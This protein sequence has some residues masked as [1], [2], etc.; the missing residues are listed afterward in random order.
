MRH[1]IAIAVMLASVRPAAADHVTVTVVEVAGGVA[2]LDKGT[3][4]GVVRG[5][6]ITF[7]GTVFVVVEATQATAVVELGAS[8]L[9]VGAKGTAVVTKD[10]ATVTVLPKPRPLEA[11]REQW[12]RAEVPAAQQNPAHVALGSGRARSGAS[13]TVI[14]HGVAVVDKTRTDASAEGRVIASFDLM[15][16]RPLAADVDVAGRIYKSGANSL[17]RT[18][19]FVRAAQLRYGDATDPRFAI[20]RLRYAASSVGMLDGARA[21]ARFSDYEIAAFGGLVPDPVSGKPDTSASRFGAEA[22]FDARTGWRPRVAL[23]LHGSTWDGELDEK[24]VAIAASANRAA[25]W[26]DGWAEAQAFSSDNPWGARSVELTGAGATASWRERG[27][28]VAV[29][30]TFLRPE[31]SLRL[32][33]ALPPEWLC[34]QRPQPGDVPEQ[35]DTGDYWTSASLS[36]GMRGAWWSVDAIGAVGRTN[37]I[38]TTHDATGLLVGEL[39][40]GGR[41][42]FAGASAG[43]ASFARWTAGHV[44]AGLVLSR[45][46]DVAVTYRPELLDY[47]AATEP[48]VLHSGIFDIHY[49]LTAN[50]DLAMSGVGT[51]G[52]DRDVLAILSTLIWRPLP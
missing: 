14:G 32:A 39:R 17:E 5:A 26:F 16:E 47:V 3:T 45:R 36:A 13:V 34:T 22:V 1:A 35:C 41:R 7:G 43:Q 18:P 33:A 51:T 50:L 44:G 15:T 46:L 23:A 48:M 11:F 4:D 9:A 29:D 37:G 21:S 42:V 19:L 28:H 30:V 20:G 24:R 49:G 12:P 27:K 31:R 2:Y 8:T 38:D 40:S 25:F 52:S 10:A 6:R